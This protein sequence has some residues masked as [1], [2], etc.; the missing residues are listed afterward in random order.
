M[1]VT[2]ALFISLELWYVCSVG[3][4][5][6]CCIAVKWTSGPLFYLVGVVEFCSS[7]W[8]KKFL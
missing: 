1:S 4:V 5:G 3:V 7:D 6:F 8:N 2:M